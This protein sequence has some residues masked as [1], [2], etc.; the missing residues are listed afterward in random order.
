MELQYLLEGF[1]ASDLFFEGEFG[2]VSHGLA[3][4]AL[5]LGHETDMELI[6]VHT[7]QQKGYLH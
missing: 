3:K 2:A 7:G 1:D 4:N 5:K 6:G